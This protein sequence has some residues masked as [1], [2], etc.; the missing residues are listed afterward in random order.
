M[1]EGLVKCIVEIPKGS[2]VKY[3][4]DKETGLLRLDRV[5]YSSVHYPVNYGFIPQTLDYD[6]DPLDILVICQERIEPLCLVE[7]KIIGVMHMI[8]NGDNDDKIIAVANKDIAVNYLDDISQLP[9][10]T[11]VEV[12]RFFE[13]YKT[14]ENKVVEIERFENRAKALEVIRHCQERYTEI[15]LPKLQ[16]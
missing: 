2:K 9:P 4:L 10:H 13:D 3:E 11:S 7:A 12:K 8:D 14:L 5:L 6:G 15:I 16:N 1:A